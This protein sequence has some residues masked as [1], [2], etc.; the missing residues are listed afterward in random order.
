MRLATGASHEDLQFSPFFR[1]HRAPPCASC[2][3]RPCVAA[4]PANALTGE[5]FDLDACLHWRMAPASTCADTCL[6]RLACPVGAE[7]RYDAAQI[8]HSY[9]CSLDMLR[10]YLKG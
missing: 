2:D 5:D 8:R 1:V 9:G 4:C 7:H 6:A 3:R 10:H